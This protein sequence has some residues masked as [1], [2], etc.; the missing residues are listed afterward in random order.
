MRKTTKNALLIALFS[1]KP[2]KEDAPVFYI[3]ALICTSLILLGAVLESKFLFCTGLGLIL[4]VPMLL[5]SFRKFIASRGTSRQTIWTIHFVTGAAMGLLF[6]IGLS[7]SIGE[8]VTF[9]FLGL[10]ADVFAEGIIKKHD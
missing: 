1:Q 10:L 7:A 5:G 6:L 8:L 9:S 2:S 4:L 3:S